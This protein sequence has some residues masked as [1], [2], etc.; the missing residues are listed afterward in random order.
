[1]LKRDVIV[2]SDIMDGKDLGIMVAIM[3]LKGSG[4]IL[5]TRK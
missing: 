2:G 4:K 3:N 1:M 5:N